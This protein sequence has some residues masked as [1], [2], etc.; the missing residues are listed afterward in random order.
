MNVNRREMT[1]NLSALARPVFISFSAC[2]QNSKPASVK[3]CWSQQQ[4]TS[5]SGPGHTV[6]S[7]S[8]GDGPDDGSDRLSGAGVDITEGVFRR[9]FRP[10]ASQK[11]T[12]KKNKNGCLLLQRLASPVGRVQR[13]TRNRWTQRRMTLHGIPRLLS[14]SS[15]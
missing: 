3:S 2:L 14:C 15:L 9:I 5:V 7:F 4:Y 10:R 1:S 12:N 13:L 6:H 11:N 8:P